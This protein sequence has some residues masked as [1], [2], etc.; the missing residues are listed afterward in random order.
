[1]RVKVERI[2][3]PRDGDLAIWLAQAQDRGVDWPWRDLYRVPAN[4]T[5]TTGPDGRF[6]ITGIGRDRIAELFVS[7]PTIATAQLYVLNGDGP[8]VTTINPQA[9]TPPGV[10]HKKPRTIYHARRFEHAAAPTKPIEGVIRDKDTGRP[11]AGVLLHGMVYEKQSSLWQ[12]G[13]EA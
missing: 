9:W 2:G 10:P 11:I 12:Q 5:M 8:A 6:R 13:V 7:G 1:A 4:I 3:F